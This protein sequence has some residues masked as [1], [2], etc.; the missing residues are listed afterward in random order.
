[1]QSPYA[2]LQSREADKIAVETEFNMMENINLLITEHCNLACTHCGT[3]APFAK[4]IS[5]PAVSFIEWLDLLEKKNIPF[6]WISLTGGEPFLHPEVRDGSFIQLLRTRYPSKKVGLTTNFFW[7][8]EKRIINYAPIIGMLNG[9]VAIS[10]YE[11]IVRKLGGLDKYNNLVQ[12]LIEACPNTYIIVDDRQSFQKWKFHEEECEVTGSCSTSDCFN[13]KP[14]GKLT[15]CSLAIAV[16]NIP[17]Y[18]GILQK[19]KE[20]LLDLRDLKDIDGREVFLSWSRKYPFDLC[21][22]CTMWHGEYEPWSQVR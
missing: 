8:S 9:G 10:I 4:K 14:D 5:H 3:G 17:E 11:P 6:R 18:M 2:E 16:Q 15:H 21:S 13:L 22:H 7:A 12:L 20:A 19:S 1:M